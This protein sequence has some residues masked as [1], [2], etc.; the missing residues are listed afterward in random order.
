MAVFI[1]H[2]FIISQALEIGNKVRHSPPLDVSLA[3]LVDYFR[4]L[5]TL[6]TDRKFLL[7]DQCAQR[8]VENL[9]QV[10]KHVF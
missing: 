2:V 10:K 4:T 8:A 7:T 1:K 9:R 3:D 6:L 5:T